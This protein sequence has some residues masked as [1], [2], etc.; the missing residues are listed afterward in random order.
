[1]PADAWA[2]LQGR[3][4]RRRRSRSGGGLALRSRPNLSGDEAV[5]EGAGPLVSERDSRPGESDDREHGG[6]VLG[7]AGAA[8]S[9]S[10]R[11]RRS[12]NADRALRLSRQI[13]LL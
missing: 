6:V 11:N 7:K 9:R 5:N 10:L 3:N 13:G 12:R 1:M 4:F 8:L 2:Q